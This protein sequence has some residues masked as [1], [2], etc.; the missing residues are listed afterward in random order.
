[1]ETHVGRVGELVFIM[2]RAKMGQGRAG[3]SA[4]PTP[5]ALPYVKVKDAGGTSGGHHQQ[6]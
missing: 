6:T 3:G 4:D 1:M 5:H 2:S